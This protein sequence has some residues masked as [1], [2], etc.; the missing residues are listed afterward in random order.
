MRTLGLLYFVSVAALGAASVIG[1][2]PAAAQDSGTLDKEAAEKVFPAKKPYSPAAGRNFP[3]RPLFGDTHLHTSFSMDAGAFGARLSPRDAYRFGRGEEVTASSGQLTKLSR[4]LDFL[5]VAD[6]SD[7]M[8]F[9]PDLLAGKPGLLADP[10][11]RKWYDMIQSGKGAEAAIDII[12]SFGAGKFKG[13]ILY[14]PD[15]APYRS[16]WQET[17]DAA[18]EANEPGRF[19]AIIGYEWTSNTGGNNLHR[20]VLF[21]DN[22]DRAGQVVPYTVLPPGS[23]NPRDLWK[24]MSAYE[25]KTGGDVLAIAHNGNLSNGIMFPIVEPGVNKPIDREYAETRARWERLYEATQIKGDGEAHPFLSPN[26]EFANFET[27]DKGNLDLTVV[28]TPDML[29]FEYARSALKNGLK[30]EKE[31]GI[32]PYKFGMIG[33]TDAHTGLAAVE[34]DNFFGKTSSSEPSAE[35]ATHPFVK[36]EKATIMGWEQTSSGYAAVWATENTR[37]AIFDAMERRE[38]YATTGPRMAV[39]FF[40]GFDFVAADAN[41]RSPAVVGYSKGVP[42]GGDLTAAPEG[43]APTFLVAALKD[44]IG[45]N[46]DRY[47]IVKGWLDAA[48]E[49]QEK[50]YDVAWSG[51]RKPGANGK[52]PSVG[53]TVDVANATWTNTIGAPELVAVWVDPEFDPTQRAFYYGRVLEIPTPRWTAYDAKYFGVKMP[54]EATMEMQERA[55][56]SPIWYSPAG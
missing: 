54:P 21:R 53:S 42:M 8:G 45:A 34:E 16:A 33:S 18:E 4:P 13:P 14:S 17:I 43:K 23:D 36:T 38:T 55:Y 3:T 48:G 50:V 22:G 20:N 56:T 39:R 10:L 26:D 41:S 49:V 5:V 44:P 19:T 24:W 30:L 11:G 2:L 51:D 32:N 28:K 46:L 37:H 6:H 27:W 7:N 1:A 15:S 29:E 47:Q 31:L 52:V 12:V 25:E 9:F 40:A 35:R